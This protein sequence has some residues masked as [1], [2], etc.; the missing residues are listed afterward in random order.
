VQRHRRHIHR[1]RAM[2]GAIVIG[3]LGVTGG[4]LLG[5]TRIGRSGPPASLGNPASSPS[6]RSAE[7]VGTTAEVE[8]D[9]NQTRLLTPTVQALPDGVHIIVDN[10]SSEPVTFVVQGS[11]NNAPQGRTEVLSP[12]GTAWQ[13]PPGEAILFCSRQSEEQA[14]LEIVD[15]EGLWKPFQ[16]SCLDAIGFKSPYHLGEEIRAIRSV[17]RGSTSLSSYPRETPWSEL[18]TLMPRSQLC[19]SFEMAR[20]SQ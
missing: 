17:W 11:A 6:P 14:T 2:E 19:E 10:A 5:L 15:P 18:A 13:N 12:Q 8:C 4:A 3:L 16:L 20:S 7:S 1:T 9:G